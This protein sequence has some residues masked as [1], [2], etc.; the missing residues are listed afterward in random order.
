MYAHK[1]I[2]PPP[3]S[4]LQYSHNLPGKRPPNSSDLPTPDSCNPTFWHID[5]WRTGLVVPGLTPTLSYLLSPRQDSSYRKLNE[6][7]IGS[8]SWISWEQQWDISIPEHAPELMHKDGSPFMQNKHPLSQS[9][10]VRAIH[11][12]GKQICSRNWQ[13]PGIPQPSSST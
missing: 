11:P 2:F 4:E 10:F 9:G 8:Q 12:K 5:S 1:I 6:K 7:T 13:L 3:N